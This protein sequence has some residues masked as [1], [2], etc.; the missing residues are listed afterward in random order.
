MIYTKIILI[1]FFFSLSSF[2]SASDKPTHKKTSAHYI[3]SC[4]ATKSISWAKGFE[5]QRKTDLGNGCYVNPIIAG[6]HPDPS[7]LKDGENYYM[8]FSSFDAYPGLVIWHSKDLVNW[9]PI[10]P[11][12]FKNVGSVWAPELIKHHGRYYIYF[13][14]REGNYRSN[15]AIHADSINGQ[16]SD[17]ID[18]KLSLIDPGHA[19]GEDGKRYLF[20]SGGYYIQLAEDGLSTIGELRKIYDGWKYPD[21]WVVESFFSRKDRRS[22]STENII[23]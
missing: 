22:P 9:K 16:W 3:D 1:V 18:L 8:T 19:I 20:L 11:A 13:P 14:G 21:E 4:Q 12:L 6:D 5:G 17:P 15:Y 23:I 2:L 7:I 10:A